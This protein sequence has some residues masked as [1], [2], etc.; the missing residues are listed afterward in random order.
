MQPLRAASAP[1]LQIRPPHLQHKPLLTCIISS[2]TVML[3][4][5]GRQYPSHALYLPT[6]AASA[7]AVEGT[8]SAIPACIHHGQTLILPV[9][10][11]SKQSQDQ[12]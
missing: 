9:K 6:Q 12:V 5:S 10:A 3:S 4:N 2:S 8:A 7:N 11:G 1:P